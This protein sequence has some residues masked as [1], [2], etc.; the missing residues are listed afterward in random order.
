MIDRRRSRIDASA[1]AEY[2]RTANFSHGNGIPLEQ[3]PIERVAEITNGRYPM[4]EEQLAQEIAVMYMIID[5]PRKHGLAL[6][7]NDDCFFGH[8]H[9]GSGND[10]PDAIF[11]YYNRRAIGGFTAIAVD[12]PPAPNDKRGFFFRHKFSPVNLFRPKAVSK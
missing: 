1:G 2:S 9:S 7:V 8:V 10:L 6:S 3:N 4:Q 5:Q 11:F 12:Q